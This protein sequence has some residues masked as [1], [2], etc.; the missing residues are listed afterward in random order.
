M[1]AN[2]TAKADANASAMNR[3]V[4]WLHQGA[5]ASAAA[6]AAAAATAASALTSHASASAPAA[7]AT[8]A[9]A[10]EAATAPAA[11]AAA[12]AAVAASAAAAAASTAE[13]APAWLTLIGGVAPLVRFLGRGTLAGSCD[14]SCCDSSWSPP[15]WKD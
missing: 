13:S 3:A 9:S 7:A 15:R 5:A 8:A 2:I 6:A 12:A 10:A 4:G 11:A 14:L 1:T